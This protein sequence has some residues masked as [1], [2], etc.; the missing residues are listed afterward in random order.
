MAPSSAHDHTSGRGVAWPKCGLHSGPTDHKT[1]FSHLRERC[2]GRGTPAEILN[3]QVRTHWLPTNS[4][5]GPC[6]SQ[7]SQSRRCQPISLASRKCDGT[8]TW[9]MHSVRRSTTQHRG[10]AHPVSEARTI[11]CVNLSAPGTA[12]IRAPAPGLLRVSFAPMH[13]SC[14]RSLQPEKSPRYNKEVRKRPGLLVQ[15]RSS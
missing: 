10:S 1:S 14:A 5:L 12:T 11:H 7:L 8:V 9:M 2:A 13:S 4:G 6:R 15:R 3:G